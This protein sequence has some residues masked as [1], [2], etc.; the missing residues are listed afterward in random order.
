MEASGTRK[1]SER[2]RLVGCRKQGGSGSGKNLM[3]EWRRLGGSLKIRVVQN[4]LGIDYIY[5][6]WVDLGV[7]RPSDRN[8]TIA[9]KIARKSK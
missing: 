4:G 8:R 5:S 9:N 1:I 7:Y 6:R 2:R 3:R